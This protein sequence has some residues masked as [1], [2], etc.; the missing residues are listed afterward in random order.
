MSHL[1]WVLGPRLTQAVSI[2]ESEN[3]HT[4]YSH[5]LSIEGGPLVVVLDTTNQKEV[6]P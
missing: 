3:V 4:H 2:L 5:M 6:L 1:R